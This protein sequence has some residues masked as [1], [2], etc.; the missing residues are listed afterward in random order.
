MLSCNQLMK[1]YITTTAVQD[2]T[3]KLE[4]GKTYAL[5]GPNGSGKTTFMKMAAGLI[6]PTSG[7]IQFEGQNIGVYSKAHIAYMPTEAYFYPYMTCK[8]IGNYY[9]DFF[10]DFDIEKLRYHKII[11]MTDADVDGAHIATLLLT[12]LY[13]FMPDLIKEGYVYLAQPPLYKVDRNKKSY[14]AYS[15]EELN[16]VLEEIGRD[17]NNNIQRY[18][19]LGEMDAEQLWDTTMDPEKR[20][21]L[22]VTMDEDD[23]SEIDLT[24][25]T[26]MGDKVEPRREFIEANAKYVRNLDI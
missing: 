12:F 26:L 9:H 15:D 25:N 21:L 20:I 16:Q 14:Y 3:L 17:G 24:F 6:K 11:I 8:D 4:A 1:K 23:T 19:G 22:K 7:D 5:L 13:R 2:I 18:K 10:E